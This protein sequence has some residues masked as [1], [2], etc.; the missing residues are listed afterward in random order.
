MSFKPYPKYKD[1]GVEWLGEVPEHWQ[2][3]PIRALAQSHTKAFTDGDWIE[4]PYITDDGVRLIQTGNVGIGIYKEQGFRYVSYE[5]FLK[6]KCTEVA[7]KDILICRLA[8]PVGRACLAPELEEKMIT[9]VDVVILKT[10]SEVSRNFVVY[11]LSSKFY[12]DYIDSVARGGTRQRVSRS[13]LGSVRISLPAIEEQTQIAGFLDH[14]TGKIDALIAEQE[15]LIELLKEKR[16]ATIS[17]AVTKGLNPDAPMKDS[18]IEWL[19]EVPAHWDVIPLKQ[20]ASCNDSS[21][22]EETD[23]DYEIEYIE[24]ADV[25]EFS[26]LAAGT[27]YKFSDAP[28]R[29][30]R[31]V[32]HGDV[33]VSTV[34][35]YLRAIAPVIFPPNNLI[36]STGFAVVRPRMGGL[37]GMYLGYL[38]RAEWWVSE[39]ISRSVGVSYPSINASDLMN[40]NVSVPSLTEQIQ[41]TEFLDQEIAKIDALLSEAERAIQLLKERRSALISAAVTGKIDVRDWKPKEEAA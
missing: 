16:Q 35:T 27:G 21:L 14:E 40:L 22:S 13:F 1:S 3:L 32:K 34:R 33:L 18:G 31:I 38:L 37:N 5:N 28:T 39:V 4:A 6:L 7:P 26:G 20:I 10:K 25:N 8:E 17:H 36:V 41:I 29:A 23:D 30:R 12:L 2:M 19:G 9:S 11:F 15:R 24:I